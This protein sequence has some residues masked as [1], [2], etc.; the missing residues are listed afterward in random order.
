MGEDLEELG[1][2]DE[3]E[4][5][6]HLIC[7]SFPMMDGTLSIKL[8]EHMAGISFVFFS[9]IYLL[10]CI[11]FFGEGIFCFEESPVPG[12]AVALLPGLF[13]L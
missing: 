2:P 10:S 3:G 1:I 7:L 6:P 13:I 4:F 8:L 9:Y 5:G 12:P 11:R